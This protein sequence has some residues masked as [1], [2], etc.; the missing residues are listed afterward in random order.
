MTI[1]YSK[2]HG[3]IAAPCPHCEETR[4]EAETQVH[5]LELEARRFRSR[6]TRL[7]NEADAALIS[8]RDAAVWLDI[9]DCWMKA[10]P[11]KRPTAKG[12]KSERAT[13]VFLRLES[14]ASVEDCKN[15]IAGAMFYPYRHF[16]NRVKEPTGKS[17]EETDLSD[18]MS[19][20]RDAI[21][22]F[23]RDRG[24]ELRGVREE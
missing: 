1:W 20:N 7:Q 6:I 8:R 18:I 9:L 17:A 13:K 24:A 19:I 21:F 11:A 3:E 10:F 4:A 15:A 12:I 5:H 22:D 2:D 16:N 23:L 14:G